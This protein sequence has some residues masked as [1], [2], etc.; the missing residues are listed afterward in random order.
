MWNDVQ[1]ET[2]VR[3][4]G[5]LKKYFWNEML[6]NGCRTERFEDTYLLEEGRCFARQKRVLSFDYI[7]VHPKLEGKKV[8]LSPSVSFMICVHILQGITVYFYTPSDSVD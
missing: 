3:R 4:E 8:Y 5:E 7:V 1:E 6:A 2:G